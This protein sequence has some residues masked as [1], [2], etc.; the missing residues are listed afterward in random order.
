MSV[1][2]DP[3]SGQFLNNLFNSLSE[4]K[5]FIMSSTDEAVIKSTSMSV[6]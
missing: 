5:Y 3:Q 4:T 1:M 2:T 6:L